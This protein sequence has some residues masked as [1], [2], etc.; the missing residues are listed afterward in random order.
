M[1]L[2]SQRLDFSSPLYMV[3]P[4]ANVRIVREIMLNFAERT[5]L[6]PK[7][8][9]PERYLW[10]D[11]FAVCNYLG[12]YL[13]TGD[14]QYRDLA[15]RLV[16]QV[17]SVLG[18]HRPDDSRTGWI[19]GLSDEEGQVHPTAGGLRIGKCMNERRPDELF[20]EALEWD[21]DGQYFHYLTQWM[22]ALACVS[23]T[24]GEAVFNRWAVELAKSVHARFVYE[25]RKGLEKSL[26]WKMSIDLS[27]PLVSAMGHHDPLDGLITYLEIQ[28]VQANMSGQSSQE[29]SAEISDM[30]RI[31]TGKSW[32]TDDAL[33][34]GGLLI[35]AY[36]IAG[37]LVAGSDVGYLLD[38]VLKDC[39]ASLS[40]FSKRSSLRLPADYRLAFREI[41]L[42][43]GLQ[44][45]KKLRGLVE[46]QPEAIRRSTGRVSIESFERYLP[47]SEEISAFWLKRKNRESTTWKEHQN[48]ND[49]MLATSLAPD[50]YLTP[51]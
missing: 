6:A 13:Q 8:S 28:A 37:L 50:G 1:R 33:G 44:A 38:A 29:L 49:V 43:L 34:I 32:T 7:R 9:S 11:S 48:I 45:I 46:H 19:S 30:A 3:M 47:L 41:G 2:C 16:D 10:T 35:A 39:L 4:D 5:G 36:K 40:S 27:Y 22:H 14:A 26:Y 31:C 20:D 18:R 21:R 25:P 15:L 12:L 24:T 42:A 51:P 17:H 23:R